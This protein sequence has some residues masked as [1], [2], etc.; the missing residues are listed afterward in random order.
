MDQSDFFERCR[1]IVGYESDQPWT[2]AS[3]LLGFFAAFEVGDVRL[4]QVFAGFPEA[5]ALINRLNQLYGV[6]GGRRSQ[7]FGYFSP[8]QGE[9]AAPE[10]LRCLAL[11][12]CQSM[13][14]LLVKEE[15]NPFNT[16]AYDVVRFVGRLSEPP[17]T[18]VDTLV[19]DGV[20][21]VLIEHARHDYALFGLD[22]AYYSLAND[23]DLAYWAS[24]PLYRASVGLDDPFEAFFQLWRQGISVSFNDEQPH[25]ELYQLVP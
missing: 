4:A 17:Q 12:H 13:N 22:D 6:C 18:D 24:W 19:Y 8:N 2:E 15:D 1:Q 23:Y 7:P 25:I 9:L 11:M 10:R 20:S 14:A 5:P 3:N 21:D 16:H